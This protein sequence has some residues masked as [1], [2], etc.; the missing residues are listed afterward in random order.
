MR[1]VFFGSGAFGL[2]TLEALVNRHEVPL[3]ITQPDRP[4][5]RGRRLQATPV[6]QWAAQRGLAV[7]KPERVND[8]DVIERV[9]AAAPQANVVI[10]F[11]QKVGPALIASPEYG[12]AATMNLHASL[13][14]KY[15]GAAP[16]HHA[17]LSGEAETGN[18]VFSL[19]DRMDAGDV[20]GRQR[21]PI[22]RMETTGELHDRLAAMGPELVLDVLERLEA[23]TLG[24]EPQEESQATAAPKLSK[25]QA[26]MDFS[27]PAESLRA[28][29]HGLNP[30]PGAKIWWSG[31]AGD[32]RQAL[33]LCRVKVEAASSDAA[34]GTMVAPGVIAVGTGALRLLE[35]QPPGKR[36]MPWSDFQRGTPIAVG[37]R[38]HATPTS[39]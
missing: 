27:R 10:A 19:V 29:V 24:P 35:V 13:L 34:P 17:I 16:I 36:V 26:I 20:L 3:V 21:T 22:D 12:A 4:S 33:G 5:G 30:W 37:T 32:A 18:T 11:G 39:R 28:W 38:F 15:R 1:I 8:P 2:P 14:P 23:G 9:R 7:F 6:G 25:D 31:A